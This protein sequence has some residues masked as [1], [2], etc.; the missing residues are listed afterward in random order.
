MRGERKLPIGVLQEQLVP[1]LVSRGFLETPLSKQGG[2]GR[3]LLL[4]F[5][6]G[7]LKRASGANLDL[8]DIQ[9][10]PRQAAFV[11]SFSVAPPEG[12]TLPWGHFIQSQLLASEVPERCRLYA[13]RRSITWF[14]PRLCTFAK[15]AKWRVDDAVQRAIALIPE[16]DSY[17]SNQ[18]LGPHVKCLVQEFDVSGKPR[19]TM[20]TA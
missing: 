10:H 14:A 4:A 20:R 19:I 11:L 16:V 15:P 2:S 13:N 1:A 18:A 9:V 3:E 8:L 7:H 6:L 5:P 12:V 17:F